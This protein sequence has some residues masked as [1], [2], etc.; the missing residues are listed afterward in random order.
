ML[1]RKRNKNKNVNQ[2]HLSALLSIF[3]WNLNFVQV[4]VDR[5]QFGLENDRGMAK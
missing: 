2:S 5:R 4:L 3:V 1:L